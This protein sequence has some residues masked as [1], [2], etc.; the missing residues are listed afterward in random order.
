MLGKQRG[1]GMFGM[2]IRIGSRSCLGALASE[3]VAGFVGLS[4]A[5]L[6]A[7]PASAV[8]FPLPSADTRAH[9]FGSGQPGLEWTTEGVGS[10]GEVSY[11]S[12]TQIVTMGA[13]INVLNFFDPNVGA[14]PTDVGSNCAEN[15]AQNL[16]FDVTAQLESVVVT[17]FG[18]GTF[19]I[20]VNFGSAPGDDLVVTDPDST[21][22]LTGEFTAGTFL[23]DPTT[24]LTASAFVVNGSVSGNPTVVGFASF[25][26][27][28]YA[29][30]F[31]SGLGPDFGLKVSEFFDL[32]PTLTA[33]AGPILADYAGDGSVDNATLGDFTAEG[34]GQ[35]FRVAS[36]DF[37]VPEPGAG[38]LLGSTFALLGLAARRARR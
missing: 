11:D 2:K 7:L 17:D 21:T 10:N 34:Q 14:C 15:L 22:L 18:G 38:L 3:F 26:G 36:G 25:T 5:L 28:A 13:V 1:K 30:L 32:V 16:A 19:Q 29:Q 33:L 8:T 27:G 37:T 23:G 12:A 24:G 6:L 9:T 31:D 20:D 4:G 35:L